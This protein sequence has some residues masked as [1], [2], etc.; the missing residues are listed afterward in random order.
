MTVGHDAF[1]VT[2]GEDDAGNFLVCCLACGTHTP[3]FMESGWGCQYIYIYIRMNPSASVSSHTSF[4]VTQ[5]NVNEKSYPVDTDW[6][7]GS[8]LFHAKIAE[9]DLTIQVYTY[10]FIYIYTYIFIFI[11]IYMCVCVC[12]FIYFIF[13][14]VCVSC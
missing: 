4:F 8:S 11:Y 2:V 14:C 6:A 9:E 3:E 5:V 13:L 1:N 12:T 10:I 7:L